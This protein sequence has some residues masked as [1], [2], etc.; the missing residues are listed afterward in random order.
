M[1][2]SIKCVTVVSG[3][4]YRRWEKASWTD[5]KSIDEFFLRNVVVLDDVFKFVSLLQLA[6]LLQYPR[7]VSVI[8]TKVF[9]TPCE[10]SKLLVNLQYLD[11]SDNLLTDMT[12]AETLCYGKGTLKNLRVLN[13]SGNALKVP[14]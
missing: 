5:H 10:T 1:Y 3:W 7:K 9:V 6:F 12:L 14:S 4:C 13:I 2:N 11:L 8:N